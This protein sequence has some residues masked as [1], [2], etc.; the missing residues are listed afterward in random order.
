MAEAAT[1]LSTLSAEIRATSHHRLVL[2][3]SETDLTINGVYQ[4]NGAGVIRAAG[5]TEASSLPSGFKFFA[6][7]D[8]QQY[9]VLNEAVA[10]SSAD[11][12]I[13]SVSIGPWTRVEEILA[14][15]PLRK[16]GPVLELLFNHS[17]LAVVD[18][19]LSFS[20]SFISRIQELEQN[21]QQD[22]DSIISLQ[23]RASTIEGRVGEVETASGNNTT[24]IASV[25]EQINSLEAFKNSTQT[26]LNTIGS[27]LQQAQATIE[28]LEGSQGS[29]NTE[30][31]VHSGQISELRTDSTQFK[32]D[33]HEINL[34]RSQHDSRI[35]ANSADITTI[36]G[37]IAGVKSKNTQQDTKIQALEN[38]AG[39]LAQISVST[40]H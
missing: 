16:V 36:N 25:N 6:D 17:Y 32:A 7:R 11:Q 27:D 19:Q 20:S 24:A 8:N 3:A 4:Q 37:E 40:N 9:T 15:A 13:A 22:H 5:F 21:Q 2:V 12:A 1:Y 38:A 34:A 23:G 31:G 35:A 33:I 29:Q 28:T 26:S 30:L 14:N 18:G 39:N 10:V